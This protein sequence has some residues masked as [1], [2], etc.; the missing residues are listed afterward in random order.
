M[1]S[2]RSARQPRHGRAPRP[3]GLPRSVP[4]GAALAAV[5]VLAAVSVSGCGDDSSGD[6]GQPGNREGTQKSSE[7]ASRSA[8]RSSSPSRTQHS[9]KGSTR[10]SPALP[11]SL[12]KQHPRWSRCPAPNAAQGEDAGSPQP[13]P[14]GARWECATLKAPVDYGK[15]KGKT[16]GIEMI[17]AKKRK[18]GGKRIGS[19]VFNFGGPGGSGVATLPSFAKDYEKLRG[20]YDLVSFD[21]RGVGRSAGVNCMSAKKLDAYFAADWTPDNNAEEKQLF[22][23]QNSFANGC[24]KRAGSLLP[25]LTTKNT[26]RDMDL[27]RHVLGDRKL[28]YF[29]IS[30]GTELGGVYAHLYPKKVGR[31]VL[32]SVVDPSATPEKGALSQTSG[33]RLALDNYL[34]ACVAKGEDCPVGKDPEEG[35]QK[36][37]DLLADLDAE[38]MPTDSGRKLT[39]SLAEGGIAQALYSQEMWDMLSQGLEEAFV[40]SNGTTLLLLADALNGR[41]QDGSYSTLQSSL[42]AI[43]CA[44]A[45]QRYT[46]GDIESKLPDFTHAS[47][48]FGPMSAWGLAQ[49][50][51]WPVKGQWRSPEVSA[52]GSAPILL[53]GTTGDPATPYGGTRRMKQKLGDHVAVEVTYRGEGHGAYDSRNKCVRAKVNDYLVH[54]KV[55]PDGTTCR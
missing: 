3:L 55:P 28:H 54:G 45:E 47:P 52:R 42:A 46:A 38:P 24:E 7:P 16:I 31:A 25:H 17:R 48:V 9:S 6:S 2:P 37:T 20:R 5:L 32:D 51:G 35:K 14:G 43:S 13:L 18:G 26:A 15:P 19:L 23:R 22:S 36:I 40:D 12:T 53:I 50:H 39:E 30:Y 44:D 21:P 33:F 1:R 34:R 8:S 11:A 41:N 29:G 10:R 27:M 4:P 49:C